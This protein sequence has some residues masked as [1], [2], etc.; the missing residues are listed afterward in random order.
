MVHIDTAIVAEFVRASGPAGVTPDALEKQLPAVSRSTINRRLSSLVAAG[1][2]RPIGQGR[3]TRYVMNG[4]FLLDEIRQYLSLDWQRRTP[5]SFRESMLQPDPGIDAGKASRLHHL[6]GLARKLDRKFLSHFLIDFS[7]SSSVLEGGSYSDLDTQALIE[8]GHR[9]PDKPVEDA[10]LVLGH[11]LAIE[12]LWQHQE[13]SAETI[14]A[15]HGFVTDGHGHPEAEHSDHFLPDSQRGRPREFEDVHL[16]RSAYLPPFRPGSGYVAEAFK[17]I[18]E[19]ANTLPPVRS[20]FY[21]LTRIPYLQVFANGNK[22]TARLAANLPLLRAGLLPLSFVDFNKADYIQS[23]H[24]LYELGNTQLMECLFVDGY[25]RSIVRG[26]EIP[27]QQRLRGFDP[28]ALVGQ[29]AH[30]VHSGSQPAGLLAR[31]FIA[32]DQ[33][34]AG[35]PLDPERARGSGN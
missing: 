20:A 27:L 7:W 18:V 23:M 22:R 29:L 13:I 32:P 15:I 3:A 28:E 14:C 21:L 17:R 10:L 24:A 30:Y 4:P 8:Y 31:A 16:N 25:V 19:T 5:V 1:E 9:N 26:S 34:R 12:Y 6:N 33:R 35:Q 11:K 2:I